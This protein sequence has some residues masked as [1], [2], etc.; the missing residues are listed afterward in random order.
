MF[1]AIS[2]NYKEDRLH[3]AANEF[4]ADVLIAGG[5]PVGMGLAIELGQRGIRCIVV[6]RYE[7]PQQV[8]KGQNLT[9]R[10]ME[11]FT[12]WKCDE[13]LRKMRTIPASFGIGGMTA[14]RSLTSGYH[15]DWLKRELVRPFYNADNQRLPQYQTEAVL[16]AR[17]AELQ[18]VDIRY[19][20]SVTSV[21][22]DIDG[23]NVSSVNRETGA[24]MTLRAQYV[25]GADGSR[26]IVR[27]SS[28]ISQ[29]LYDHDRVMVLLVFHSDDLNNFLSRFPGKSFINILHPELDGYWLFI[30]RVD[31]QG[32]FFFH[33]PLPKGTDQDHF[34]FEGYVQKAVG[35]PVKIDIRYKGFWDCRVAIA[36]EYV[37]G[38][39]AVAGDAAHSHPPYGGYG[40][41]TG[42]EDARN[43]GW[44]L[45]GTLQGWGGANL[46]ASYDSERRPVFLSTAKDFI[47]KSIEVDR[48]FLRSYDPV[49]DKAAFEAEWE[50]RSR[51]AAAEVHSFQPNY[52]GSRIVYGSNDG[53][54]DAIGE[55]KFLARPGYHL[56]PAVLSDG[57][58]VY[59]NLGEGF[60]LL[61]FSQAS[62]L[63]QRFAEAASL[64]SL[65]L[66]IVKVPHSDDTRRYGH[67]GVLV[68]PDNFVSWVGNVLDEIDERAILMKC[69][70]WVGEE[71]SEV[72]RNGKGAPAA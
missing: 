9:Q 31:T 44:K 65:P 49:E 56:A 57:S 10:T 61:I 15:Y 6:E 12:S 20:W 45:A 35:E 53:V 32:S 7:H 19:G 60:T 38:R 46:L 34:D 39:I 21:D 67:D 23:V 51:E 5:G 66:S 17:A 29:T 69:A 2:E 1:S 8:P 71:N 13:A 14:Y 47:E 70:G 22:E 25:V 63:E 55:H 30:G 26:S 24:V 16:R 43:L 40:I 48:Q 37:K 62:S 3:M 72:S 28:G 18:T 33:A 27:K 42:F 64:L 36:D 59:E 52:R 50:R 4:D 41:N 54:A 68:R 58:D 11:H